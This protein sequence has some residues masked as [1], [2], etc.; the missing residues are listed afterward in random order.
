MTDRSTEFIAVAEMARD[1]GERERDL[2]DAPP[3]ALQMQPNQ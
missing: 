2:D 1:L 3:A